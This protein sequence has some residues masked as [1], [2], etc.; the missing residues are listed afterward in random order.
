MVLIVVREDDLELVGLGWVV[1]LDEDDVLACLEVAADTEVAEGRL[2]LGVEVLVIIFAL[3]PSNDGPQ[4]TMM[5][6]LI[7]QSLIL[8]TRVHFL[9][10]NI[11]LMRLFYL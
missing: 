2:Q 3:L 10:T 11:R 6:A 5:S 4:I 9:K 1:G 7:D 8:L